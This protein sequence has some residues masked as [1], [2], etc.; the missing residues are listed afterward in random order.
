MQQR[1]SFVR[2]SHVEGDWAKVAGLWVRYRVTGPHDAPAVMLLHHFHGNVD[3]WRH[4][5][6]LLTGF[7]VISFDRPGFGY[8][9]RPARSAWRNGN[10]YTRRMAANIAVGLL[11]QLDVSSA[12][13]VGS[14]A[15]GT[16]ALE[17][18][19]RHPSRVDGLGLISPA[20]TGDAGA[21]APVRPVLRSAPIRLLG[22]A[23]ADRA[24]RNV[25]HARVGRSWHDPSRV[26]DEDVEVYRR[27]MGED[28]WASATFEAM[29]AEQPPDLRRL[30][31]T[32]E[33]PTLVI[34]GVS[35]PLVSP[36]WNTRTARAIPSA[37]VQLLDDVG[38]T[39]HEERP[40]LLCETL[41]PWL[42]AI[43]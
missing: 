29:V 39:P 35:D 5:H 9:E 31:R 34:G 40:E 10:P 20:I 19:A 42:H 18:F 24:A 12:T 14:S 41:E 3:T 22:T 4:V 23:V 17:I 27:P 1:P 2:A 36:R 13:M 33:I 7:R 15:G 30:L 21:P 37:K 26:T 43:T 28:R 11:G 38:H 8:T 32:I 16:T 6:A 25:A